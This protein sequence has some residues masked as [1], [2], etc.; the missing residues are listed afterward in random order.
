MAGQS[1]DQV[2]PLF[3]VTLGSFVAPLNADR[4]QMSF[5][6]DTFVLQ[7]DTPGTLIV[8]SII[9]LYQFIFPA[10]LLSLFILLFSCPS[11]C[12]SLC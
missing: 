2:L 3:R 4:I 6:D 10:R 5:V 9:L 11:F 1:V 12:P 7:F 8:A